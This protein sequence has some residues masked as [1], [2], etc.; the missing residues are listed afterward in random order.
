MK[1]EL[2][3]G[4]KVNFPIFQGNFFQNSGRGRKFG[5]NTFLIEQIKCYFEYFSNF[6]F[7]RSKDLSLNNSRSVFQISDRWIKFLHNT[8]QIEHI[9]GCFFQNFNFFRVQRSC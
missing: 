8:A 4:Q 1:F 5:Y 7:F 6:Q 2:F 9:K 3:Q